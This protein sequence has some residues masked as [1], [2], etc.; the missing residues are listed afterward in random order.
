MGR[1]YKMK[2]IWNKIRQDI[3]YVQILIMGLLLSGG[4]ILYDFSLSGTQMVLTFLAGIFTQIFW[5][6]RLK[7]NS[8]S[9]LSALITCLGLALLLRANALWIHPLV[10]S[11]SISSK[12]LIQKSGRHIFNPS[13]LGLVLA[14]LVFPNTWLSPGQWGANWAYSIWF[15]ALG[16]LAATRARQIDI[17]WMF[18][19][20]YLGG[21]FIRNLYLGYEMEILWHTAANGSLLLFAFF[22]ISD[23]KTAPDHFLGKMIQA[24]SVALS[25]LFL[26]YYVFTQNGFVWTL[27]VSSF[28]VPFLNQWLKAPPFYW[29]N[30]DENRSFYRSAT[31]TYK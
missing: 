16:S 2:A 17:S 29:R 10:A 27:V 7:L 19:I 1:I 18:L 8:H 21:L 20:F 3:R 25:S 9:L 6:R 30:H 14:L 28:F 12:Y 26:H 4:V 11:L 13:A 24:L 15:V 22:M 5:I 31:L 23:P